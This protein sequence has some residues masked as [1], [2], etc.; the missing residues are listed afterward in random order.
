MFHLGFD[1]RLGF[2]E[3]IT[4]LGN[5]LDVAVLD[6]RCS[7]IYS[8]DNFHI[9]FSITQIADADEQTARSPLGSLTLD[10]SGRWKQCDIMQNVI[11]GLKNN[12]AKKDA[13]DINQGND[14]GSLS[15]LLYGIENLRKRGQD[16]P[17]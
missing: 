7:I 5:V 15:A 13:D 14:R 1:L 11:A 6:N 4:C 17:E 9:P 10:S 2:R 3:Y 8:L 16:E 12:E